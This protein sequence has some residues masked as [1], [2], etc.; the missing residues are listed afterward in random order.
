MRLRRLERDKSDLV[1]LDWR[2]F[3]LRPRPSMSRTLE[4]FRAYTESWK[5]PAADAD[6]AEFRVWQSDAGPPSHSIPPHLVA[7]AAAAL[8]A[9][10]FDRVHESLLRA[11]FYDNR[12]ITD[13]ATLEAI[14][15]ECDLP[16]DAF[17]RREDPELLQQVLRE[18]NEAQEHGASGVSRRAC[19]RWRRD[20][21]RRAPLR[22]LRAMGGPSV[23]SSGRL[24][25]YWYTRV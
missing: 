14:W 19:R 7:K 6:G 1:S 5:R 20:H 13:D 8:G 23:R 11:Y 24:S 3:L 10:Q 4:K 17:A 21:R 15:A 2:S 12:D 22:A 25:P 16:P 18:H 9:E